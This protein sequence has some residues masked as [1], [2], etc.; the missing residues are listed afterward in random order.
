MLL[1]IKSI[2]DLLPYAAFLVGA[3][4]GNKDGFYTAHIGSRSFVDQEEEER[5][6]WYLR[7]VKKLYRRCKR[8]KIEFTEEYVQKELSWVSDKTMISEIYRR[9][10][11]HPTS[12]NVKGLHD[13]LHQYYRRRLA[14]EMVKAGYTQEQADEWVY[15]NNKT[16]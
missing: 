10:K 6:A 15:N 16:W 12:A 13:N 11:E 14:E 3:A 5:F 2:K 8:K 4:G 1:D 9:V 7:D